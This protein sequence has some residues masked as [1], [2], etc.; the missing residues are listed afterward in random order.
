MDLLDIID[1][2]RFVGQE[3]LTWLWFKSEERGGTIFLP[4]AGEDIQ[5]VF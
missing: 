2:K 5:L 4:E 3:F 1:E